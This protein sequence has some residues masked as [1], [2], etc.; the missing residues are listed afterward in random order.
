LLSNVVPLPGSNEFLYDEDA[1]MSVVG[2]V[3]RS[4]QAV[5]AVLEHLTAADFYRLDLATIFT[6]A[7]SLWTAGHPVDPVSVFAKLEELGQVKEA[8]GKARVHEVAEIVTATRNA[9]HHARTVKAMSTRRKTLKAGY[10]LIELAKGPGEVPDILDEA[11]RSVFALQ[12]DAT[13]GLVALA[14]AL[15]EVFDRMVKLSTSPSATIGLPSG[16]PSLDR[17]TLGFQPGNLLILAA[18]PSM[19]KSALALCFAANVAVRYELPVAFFTLEMSKAETVQR[20]LA[21][22]ANVDLQKV[23][24][25][26]THKED[27][28]RL[29]KAAE[30]LDGAPFY[31]DDLSS[32]SMVEIRS[33]ARRLKAQ[34]PELALVVVDYLQLLVRGRHEHK[35]AETGEIARQLKILAKD[36]GVPV[37]ALAQLSRAVE[38]RNDKRPVLSDLRDSGEIE[39]HADLCL[40]L[41]RDDY[42][43][44]DSSKAPGI[45]ELNIAKHRNG[46]TDKV[47][48]AWL[49]DRAKFGEL[50]GQR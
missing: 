8:G 30:N 39:Q 32:Q 47:K 28:S 45:A 14:P 43:H 18:R 41:Y 3:L 26:R 9:A 31:L 49:K 7:L 21:I 38:S 46:P 36:L 5:D 17:L 22:E 13:D 24:T 34:V 37:L 10:R 42:Y 40:F 1:E 35:V 20:L 15:K 27:W 33:K 23:R 12:D 29:A 44:P 19:G 2:A 4:E 50:A 16:Y 25:G 6:A 11:E 48:L